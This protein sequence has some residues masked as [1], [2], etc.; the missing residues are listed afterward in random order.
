M[1]ISA[2]RRTDI[3]ARYSDWFFH[4]LRA[5]FAYVR[6]PRNPRRIAKVSLS[7]DVVDGII[8]WTKN[9]IP[10]LAR[11]PELNEY[12]YY[13]Q[14][15]LN[16]YGKEIEPN[17]PSK[18][19]CL[20]PAFQELSRRIG[21]ERVVWRYD[22]ILFHEKY[23][24]EYHR[25]YFRVLTE[26]LAGYTEECTVS[27]LDF[28]P[29]I[30]RSVR[31]MGIARPTISQMRELM[32]YFSE[33]AGEAGIRLSACAEQTDFQAWGVQRAHCVDRERLERLGGYK[34]TGLK[35]D[36]NQR[37]ACG[38]VSSVDIGAYDTCTHGCR[39]CY[40]NVNVNKAARNFFQHDPLAPLLS[41][42]ITEADTVTVRE[43]RSY[44]EGQMFF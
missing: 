42:T 44:R 31:E 21:K 41:G 4:R 12:L 36:Q 17:V 5:G 15:T 37:F 25:K 30:Q 34:L 43:M 32:G 23:A 13:F 39:Y 10:M 6:N 33:I 1:V 3:P 38:C 24:M 35:P 26:K 8:F 22:P 9:P 28:Y 11:L 29:K 14:F 27:F 18:K 7:P 40:A 16:P 19:D 20:L 2:S